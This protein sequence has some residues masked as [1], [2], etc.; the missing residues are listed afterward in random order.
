MKRIALIALMLAGCSTTP[1]ERIKIVEKVVPVSEKP[2][3]ATDIPK[4]PAPLGPRPTTARAAADTLLAKVCE[5][6]SYADTADGLMA[7]S[8]GIPQPP[9]LKFPECEER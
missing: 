2:I 1:P 4:V 6:V 7:V 8:A 3:A 9:P 5:F